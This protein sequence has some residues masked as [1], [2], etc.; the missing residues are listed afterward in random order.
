MTSIA[1]SIY[2]AQGLPLAMFG[3]CFVAI[4]TWQP[5]PTHWCAEWSVFVQRPVESLYT[6]LEKFDTTG[7]PQELGQFGHG[8][9]EAH[10]LAKAET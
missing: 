3:Q 9:M 10:A 4:A 7:Y 8:E 2:K 5:A 1:P 6:D